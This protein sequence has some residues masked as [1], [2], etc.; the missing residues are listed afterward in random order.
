MHR[1]AFFA[2]A[3]LVTLA[4]CG[5][6]PSGSVGATLSADEV[7]ALGVGMAGATGDALGEAFTGGVSFN[8]AVAEGASLDAVSGSQQFSR[9]RACP[10]GGTITVSGTREGTYDPATK[11]GTW[12]ETGTRQEAACVH[13]LR[14]DRTVT[15][16][17]APNVAITSSHTRA[18]GVPGPWTHTEKGAFD[19]TTSDGRSGHCTV[20]VTATFTPSAGTLHAQGTLCNRTFDRTVTHGG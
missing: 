11:S 7:Q 5:G 10:L 20:D 15:V 12:T 2:T 4:A 1:S 3:A 9:T 18:N 6:D 13:A 14:R 17:G 8:V 16:N 19:W